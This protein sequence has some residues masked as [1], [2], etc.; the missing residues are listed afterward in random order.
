MRPLLSSYNAHVTFFITQFDSL[1]VGE[2]Q[3]LKEFEA[4]GHEIASHGALH[5]LSEQYIKEHS[6]N[7]YL[8]DEIDP[9]IATLSANGFPPASFAYPYGSKYWFTDMLLLQRFDIVR[10]VVAL[11]DPIEEMD[12]IFYDFDNDRTVFAGGIDHGS[13]LTGDKAKAAIDRAAEHNEVLLLYGHT[14]GDSSDPYTF[15]IALL[16]NILASAAEKGLKFYRVKDLATHNA[17]WKY[18]SGT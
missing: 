13:R 12:D 17:T 11:E 2:R 10:G 18:R 14:P 8:E 15:D 16:Q 7:E 4:D 6:Y 1:S 5:V 9:D 3:L